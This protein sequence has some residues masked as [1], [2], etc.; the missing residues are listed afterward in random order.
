VLG[1][2]AAAVEGTLGLG[3]A[4][5]ADERTVE[6]VVTPKGSAP[7]IRSGVSAHAEITLDGAAD[8][9]AIPVAAVVRDGLRAIYFRRDPKNAD[10]AIRTDAD[11]GISD[12]R[13]IT[14]L[15]G[16][17]E[18]EEVVV[19]GVYQ[20]LLATAGN[21]QKGGHFHADGTFHDGED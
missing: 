9:V 19:D 6:L 15:S 11:T 4:S 13:W 14:V 3:F 10:V 12:G 20:L 21:A 8:E 1:D 7:W 2:A 18:G 16:I 17:R 5:D